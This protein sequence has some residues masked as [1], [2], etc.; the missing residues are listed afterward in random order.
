MGKY[1][2]KL[3]GRSLEL[4]FCFGCQAFYLTFMGEKRKKICPKCK[5]EF[6]FVIA[7]IEKV[8]NKKN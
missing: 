1:I 7:T 8:E 5:T 6:E 4:N 2:H 3:I